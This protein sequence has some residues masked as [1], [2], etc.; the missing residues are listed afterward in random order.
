MSKQVS[1][2]KIGSIL[3]KMKIGQNSIYALFARRSSIILDVCVSAHEQ[4]PQS[5]G[6]Q[7][8]RS[9]V[10]L[11][12]ALQAASVPLITITQAVRP[13][14]RFRF[15]FFSLFSHKLVSGLQS[16]CITCARIRHLEFTEVVVVKSQ[17]R[18][19]K[20]HSNKHTVGGRPTLKVV[21]SFQSGLVCKA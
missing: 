4:Y 17:L 3:Q 8:K 6:E 7:E 10:L 16:A 19:M 2:P 21:K 12:V 1:L 5:H 14:F 15:S 9:M 20:S 11:F 18:F 13:G